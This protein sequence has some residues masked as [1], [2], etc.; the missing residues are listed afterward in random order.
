MLMVH[1]WGLDSQSRRAIIQ[2][3]IPS[4]ESLLLSLLFPLL[5]LLP[6]LLPVLLLLPFGV[7]LH[8]SLIVVGEYLLL[9]INVYRQLT[10][11]LK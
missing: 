5:L 10:A 2:V 3:V 7:C 8:V 1:T 9:A 11:E 4:E 6:V